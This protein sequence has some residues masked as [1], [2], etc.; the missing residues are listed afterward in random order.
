MT[1]EEF[2]KM[3]KHRPVSKSVITYGHDSAKTVGSQS[4]ITVKS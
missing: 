1:P 3:L 4:N 2:K